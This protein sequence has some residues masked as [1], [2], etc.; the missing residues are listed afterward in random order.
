MNKTEPKWRL[1]E[2]YGIGLDSYNWKLYRRIWG[3][4]TS[5]RA[6]WRICGYFPT[7]K[8]LIEG[9]QNRMMLEDSDNP[10]LASHVEMAL[11]VHTD[12]CSS[13]KSQLDSMGLDTKP[14]AYKR[15]Q[16]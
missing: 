8:M 2:D 1:S 4:K 16:K 7:L 13:L 12:A 6:G 5:R 10:D 11:S 3:R 14:A 15:W 9:M